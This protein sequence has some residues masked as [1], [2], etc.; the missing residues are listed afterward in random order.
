MLEDK[1]LIWKL[2]RGDIEVL[3]RIYEKYKDDLVTLAGALLHNA[4]AAEDVVHEVF[5]SFIKGA[6]KF[7]LTGS[8]RGFLFTCVANASRNRYRAAQR[9]RTVGLQQAGSA[10]SDSDRPDSYAMFGEELAKLNWALA[11]LPYEQREVLLMRLKA[12]MKFKAIAKSQ[13]VSMSTVQGRYRYG[14]NKLRS[15]LNSE[16]DK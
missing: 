8:L 7:R 2:N 12:A 4:A 1:L 10:A 11:S 5:V 9:Q 13:G 15:L 3:G 6:E 14:L 16:T